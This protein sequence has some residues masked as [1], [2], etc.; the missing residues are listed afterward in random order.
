MNPKD[1]TLRALASQQVNGHEEGREDRDE[2][3][4]V[5]EILA[6]GLRFLL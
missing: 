2:T 6:H 4:D 5:S 1:L 3:Y